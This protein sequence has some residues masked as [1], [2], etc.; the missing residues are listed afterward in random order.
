[1]VHENEFFKDALKAQQ[2]KLLK[3]SRDRSY[4]L[5]RLSKYEKPDDLSDASESADEQPKR[6]KQETTPG[7][8][9][10]KQTGQ[11]RRRSSKAKSHTSLTDQGH[12][13]FNFV[14]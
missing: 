12:C 7:S 1:M 10:P 6:K 8:G 11:K 3:V 4:L 13:K 9:D 14:N 5:D 2:Q